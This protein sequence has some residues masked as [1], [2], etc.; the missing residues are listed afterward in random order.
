MSG[1][2]IALALMLTA[3]VVAQPPSNEAQREAIKKLDFWTG[4]WKGSGSVQFGPQQQSSTVTETV[5][6]KL[7]GAVLLVQGRGVAMVEG[8]EMIV[9]DALAVV[10]YDPK[11]KQYRFR[12]YTKDG[13]EGETELK[14]ID[15]GFQWELKQEGSPVVIRFTAKVD[16]KTWH[17]I[18]EFSRDGK[19]W[20]KVMEMT[21]TKQ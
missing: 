4:T 21:L 3:P 7:G 1:R 10:S 18:G 13:R 9:H 16:G 17:E 11:S 12:H 5:E 2:A 14:Q 8:K 15:G 19:S 6:A 20:Q